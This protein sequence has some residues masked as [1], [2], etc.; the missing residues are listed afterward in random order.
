MP[1]SLWSTLA[2]ENQLPVLV[3]QTLCPATQ[4]RPKGQK[5]PQETTKLRDSISNDK[6][7]Q[8][9]SKGPVLVSYTV[10]S[11]KSYCQARCPESVPL[12]PQAEQAVQGNARTARAR[13]PSRT[14]GSVK[15]QICR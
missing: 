12:D 2:T 5:D 1:H 15:C 7:G 6:K 4:L 8:I 9:S 10:P 3:T 13:A 11:N 14:F